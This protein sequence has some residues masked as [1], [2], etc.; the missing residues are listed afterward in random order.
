MLVWS[1]DRLARSTKHFLQVLDE[2][3]E[4]GIQFHSQREAI[5]TDG[6]LGRTIVVIIS[7]IAELE[8]SLIVERVRAG[9]R[10]IALVDLDRRA[11][12]AAV[13]PPRVNRFARVD[14]LPEHFGDQMKDFGAP[15]HGVG[16]IPHLCS[17][18][19]RRERLG[20]RGLFALRSWRTGPRWHL[21]VSL[22]SLLPTELKRSSVVKVRKKLGSDSEELSDEP[23]FRN[24]VA[25]CH[26]SDAALADHAHRFDTLERSPGTLKGAVALGQ[27]GPLFDGSMILFNDIVEIFAL[28][29]TN[30]AGESTLGFQGFH[31]RRIGPGSYPR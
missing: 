19:R 13:E 4:L 7:A 27:P 31:C 28:P 3:N 20:G 23:R 5:D 25:L 29:Q 18:Y 6:P 24:N 26:A 30:S 15:I 2:L 17:H 8:R 11:G 1:C 22:R 14:L 21:P 12:R 10:V 16:E 9:M